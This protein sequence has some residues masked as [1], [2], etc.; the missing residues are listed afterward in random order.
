MPQKRDSL[1]TLLKKT[2]MTGMIPEKWENYF[3]W[4]VCSWFISDLKQ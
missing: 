2:H 3:G 4:M 1:L